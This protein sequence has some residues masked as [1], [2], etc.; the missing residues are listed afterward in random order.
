MIHEL[1]RRRFL[2]AATS[3]VLAAPFVSR[4]AAGVSPNS[5]LQHASFGASGMAGS[6]IE[7]LSAHPA[8]Q[9]V[10]VADVDRR[11]LDT[12]KEKLKGRFPELRVY[13]DWR[14]LLAKE[15]EKIDSVNVSTPD[16]MHGPIGIAA[17]D[18]GK[19]AYVQKPLTHNLWECREITQRARKKGVMSQMGIQVSSEFT[20]R[21]AVEIVQAGTIGKV[22][23]VHT[24]S[25]KDWG[26]LAPV[27]TRI[28]TPPPHFDW[29]LWLGVAKDRPFIEGYYHPNVWRKR[30][31][32]G[33]ATLGDMGCHIFS[34]WFRGLALTAPLSVKST[35][36]KPPNGTNWGLHGRVEYLFP[37][38][39][40][41]EGKTVRVTWYDGDSR[42]PG[43]ILTVIE[44][45][46]KDPSKP[47]KV[48]G[49]GN[50]IVGTDGVM[51]HP[52]GGTPQL[53]P[54]QKFADFKYPKLEPRDHYKEFI[55]KCLAGKDRPSANFDY[56]GPLSESVLLG[57]LASDFPNEVLEWNAAE[58][59]IGNLEGAN[60]LV[61]REYRKGWEIT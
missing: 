17:V 43:E 2:Q 24:F 27:P 53:F 20:E 60:K 33:T 34:A 16:H 30:R 13:Q 21:F 44:K 56:A 32:F 6:D 47:R 8:F 36:P 57:C 58:L 12:L 31:D 49:Q 41:T 3:S 52:H 38:T 5:R 46:Q 18:L 39:Q 23:E 14:E 22:K 28:D 35:G 19:H 40:F 10:A 11:S 54:R 4:G 1:T 51:L 48:P 9:L 50:I 59:K 29:N 45:D 55:D 7:S 26:D 37:G 61:K 42:P 25:S 15:A